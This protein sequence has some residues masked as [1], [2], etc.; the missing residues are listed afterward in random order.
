MS[1]LIEKSSAGNAFP[2]QT[3]AATSMI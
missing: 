3:P 1:L 2:V